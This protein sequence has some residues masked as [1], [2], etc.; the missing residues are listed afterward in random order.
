MML[1]LILSLLLISVLTMEA[2]NVFKG[3]LR[4]LVGAAFLI[5]VSVIAY[6]VYGLGSTFY[7]LFALVFLLSIVSLLRSKSQEIFAYL[8]LF[9]AIMAIST[10]LGIGAVANIFG[11]LFYLGLCLFLLRGILDVED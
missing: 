1:K 3:K 5:L 8:I 11:I 9:V 4:Y 10:L 7:F 6:K 2:L